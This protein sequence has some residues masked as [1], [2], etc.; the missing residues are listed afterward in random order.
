MSGPRPNLFLI[1]AKKAGTTSLQRYLG[2]HP[3]IFMSDPKEPK[4]FS[5]KNNWS[6]GNGRYLK[7]FEAATGMPIVGE[8]SH[9]Y[10]HLPASKGVAERI[11]EFNPSA[12]F[13]YIVRDPIERAISQYW[14]NWQN[15]NEWRDPLEAIKSDPQYRDLSNY[16]L[17]LEPYLRLFGRAALKIIVLEELSENPQKKMNEVYSWLGVESSLVKIDTAIH[18]HKTGEELKRPRKSFSFMTRGLESALWIR[19]R[20]SIP[21]RVRSLVFRI[22]GERGGRKNRSD[23]G[24]VADYLRDDMIL[25][26]AELS[27]I[28][29]R[30]FPQWTTLFSTSE[31]RA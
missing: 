8:A 9:H 29:G 24:E 6:R 31:S 5:K 28:A 3:Q 23:L 1:G 14:W 15:G 13:I 26:T 12:R 30:T 11:K 7:L 16:P 10:T 27:K 25:Q 2:L 4:H 19:L 17:Q 22:L 21:K 18:I 20:S